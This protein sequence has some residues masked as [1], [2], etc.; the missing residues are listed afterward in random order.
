MRIL[1]HGLHARSRFKYAKPPCM[2]ALAV[3]R[4]K[5]HAY[6]GSRAGATAA[7]RRRKCASG[8]FTS[9]PYEDHAPSSDCG[10]YD[11]DAMWMAAST[12]SR[13]LSPQDGE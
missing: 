6:L 8:H 1:V 11:L 2:M 7:T 13:R 9:R 5:R 10:T 4:K 12:G 3:N